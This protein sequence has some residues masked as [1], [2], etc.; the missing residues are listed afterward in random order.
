MN[1]RAPFSVELWEALGGDPAVL[2]DLSVAGEGDLPSVYRV[3]DFA[4]AAIGVAGLATAELVRAVEARKSTGRESAG[5]AS[6]GTAKPDTAGAGSSDSRSAV[7][8]DRTIASSWFG[9]AVRPV[10]W[11]LPPVWDAL[12]RNYRAKDGWIRLHTNAPH[13]RA[14][15]M[16]VL[17]VADDYLSVRREVARWPAEALES[18]IVDAGGCAAV[19]RSAAEWAR[20]PQGSMVAREPLLDWTEGSPRRPPTHW[21]PRAD[22]P[23][24]GLRVLDLTRVIAGPVATRFLAGLGA[25]VL[26]IDPPGWDED[27]LVPNMTL[28]KR[29]AR[30][31]ARTPEGAARLRELLSTADVL[32]HGYRNGALDALGLD[33]GE[34]HAL[35]PGLIDASLDAYGFTGPWADRRGFDSLVQMSCGIVH[36]GTEWAWSDE[37]H[38]LPVQALD[39]AAGYV[40]AAAVLRGI[41]MSLADGHG[42]SVRTSLARVAL[43]LVG[44]GELPLD[45]PLTARLQPQLPL[46]TPWGPAAI[47]PAPVTIAG[48]PVFFDSPPRALGSDAPEWSAQP[49]GQGAGQRTGQRTGS[50]SPLGMMPS[51]TTR[52]SAPKAPTE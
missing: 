30:I 17:N 46:E 44:G 29:S 37:P 10:G 25:D 49:A 12:A 2:D 5:A 4:A 41:T 9:S 19:M 50:A 21:D 33:A 8:V 27:A 3:T 24:A 20:H 43:C 35:R 32:V 51:E 18:A 45:G 36:R 38:P 48:T 47:L 11:S 28:G 52:A 31:D 23:L 34:R 13:H 6:A 14:A 16:S 1:H 15:A 40:L 42:R 7:V 26:R 22:R 39:H